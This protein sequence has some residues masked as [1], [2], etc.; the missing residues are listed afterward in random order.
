L[1]Q[2]LEG[3]DS[4]GLNW[5]PPAPQANSLYVLATHTLA[6]A[7]QNILGVLCG[8]AVERDREAEFAVA[9]STASALIEQWHALPAPLVH[10]CVPD[11]RA[12]ALAPKAAQLAALRKKIAALDRT[13][14]LVAIDLPNPPFRSFLDDL[15]A[16]GIANF[17]RDVILD[18]VGG[19]RF[20]QSLRCLAPEGRLL[21]IG[22]TEGRIPSV[23]VNRRLLR[24]VSVVGVAWGRA[25]RWT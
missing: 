20:D 24:N 6:N 22:F 17:D 16:A 4:V 14:G 25:S 7:Q 2:C 21:V 18:P 11:Y 15:Q 12:S 10:D 13:V 3:L 23:Q 5:R 8:Q 19:D 1:L 9:G